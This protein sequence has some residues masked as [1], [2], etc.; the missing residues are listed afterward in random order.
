MIAPHE[1]KN[2][3]FSRSVRGYNPQEVDEYF[4]FLIEKYTEAYKA[5]AEWERK[6]NSVQAKYEELSNEEESIRSAI[7]KAQK[8]GEVIV[9]NAKAEAEEH[10]SHLRKEC[11]EIVQEAKDR[12][13]VEQE[14]I[15][16]LRA[17]AVA[18]QKKLYE[19]YVQ[20]ITLIKE[21]KLSELSAEDAE[22]ELRSSKLLENAEKRVLEEAGVPAPD[23]EVQTKESHEN[24]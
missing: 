22:N 12:V 17:K 23:T 3:T 8:L 7:L 14:A 13:Q 20:H 9:E 6:Y 4:D 19:D 15:L 16:S 10:K 1:L 5:I 18:F 21:M 24:E 2:K 11:D